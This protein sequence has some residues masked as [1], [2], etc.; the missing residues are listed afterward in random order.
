MDKIFTLLGLVTDNVDRWA[1]IDYKKSPASVYW[2]TTRNLLFQETDPLRILNFAGIGYP[3]ELNGLLSWVPD[4][5]KL[6]EAS[7]GEFILRSPHGYN[8]SGGRKHDSQIILS[9]PRLNE[10][11][12]RGIQVDKVRIVAK[13]H[14]FE[15]ISMIGEDTSELRKKLALWYQECCNLLELWSPDPYPTSQSRG[16]AFWRTLIGDRTPEGRPAPAICAEYH[17]AMGE[18]I[19]T[20]ASERKDAVKVS[21]PVV[22]FSRFLTSSSMI[23]PGRRFCVTLG[24]Y[25]GWVP[26]YTKVGDS[27]CAFAGTIAPFLAR[28]SEGYNGEKESN[29]WLVGEC[30]FHGMMDGEMV[31]SEQD[32]MIFTLC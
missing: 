4:W 7:S 17:D 15:F 8:A 29:Y 25:I 18:V 30:Y 21:E 11:R 24:G 6:P 12:L 16:E 22:K 1:W 23:A 31:P 20:P 9:S 27:V 14:N 32:M 19:L 26:P 28:K 10:I 3:W 5:N 2:Q 13:A